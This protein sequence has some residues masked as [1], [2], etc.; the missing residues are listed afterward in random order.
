M[1]GT[2]PADAMAQVNAIEPARALHRPVMHSKDHRIALPQRHHLGP[3]LHP[4][5]LLGQHELAA[6]EIAPWFRQQDRDLQRK[7]VLAIEVLVQAVVVALAILQQ[8]RRRPR[9]ARRRGSASG[10]P[11]WSSG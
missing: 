5:P 10:T 2:H 4:R 9:A 3:R 11:A 6:G 7:H 8:Q 1:A